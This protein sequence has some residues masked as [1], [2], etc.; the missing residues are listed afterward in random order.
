MAFFSDLILR[1]VEIVVYLIV[2]VVVFILLFKVIK[3]LK[4][5][6]L[7][8]KEQEQEDDIQRRSKHYGNAKSTRHKNRQ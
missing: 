6:L 1:I 4:L 3:M 2:A 8:K 7:F 5:E